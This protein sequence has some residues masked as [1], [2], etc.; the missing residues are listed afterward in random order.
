MFKRMIGVAAASVVLG[1][2]VASPATAKPADITNPVCDGSDYVT[3]YADSGSTCYANAGVTHPNI[4]GVWQVC[5][6]NNDITVSFDS[7]GPVG[8][9]IQRHDCYSLKDWAG[10]SYLTTLWIH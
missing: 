8:H 10:D 4:H 5:S 7:G 9:F 1:L 6:G 2:A 3:V